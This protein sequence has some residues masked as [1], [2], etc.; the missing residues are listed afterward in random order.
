MTS[1]SL[2]AHIL[3]TPQFF[4]GTHWLVFSPGGRSEPI[5][6]M[7]KFG[8]LTNLISFYLHEVGQ[9]AGL[10]VAPGERQTI[11]V[12]FILINLHTS[13]RGLPGSIMFKFNF[14]MQ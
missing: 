8:G 4:E 10:V 2:L 11:I 1:L 14:Q 5:G 12:E 9:K 6:R 13:S 7:S 3:P